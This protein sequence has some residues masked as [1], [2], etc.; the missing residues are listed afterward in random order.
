MRSLRYLNSILTVLAVLLALQLWTTFTTSSVT[1]TTP[2]AASAQGVVNPSEQRKDMIELLTKI[3]QQMAA[4]NDLLR[5][6]QMKV[7]VDMPAAASK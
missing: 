5:S 2:Q 3:N 6:G 4:T 1:L 7:Q